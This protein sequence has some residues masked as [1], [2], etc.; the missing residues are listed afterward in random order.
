M[1]SLGVARPFDDLEAEPF[2]CGVTTR[3]CFDCP[4]HM[5]NPGTHEVSMDCFFR[6]GRRPV[7][8]VADQM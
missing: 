5:N 1:E 7:T 8:G 3:K 4:V 2:L 6:S